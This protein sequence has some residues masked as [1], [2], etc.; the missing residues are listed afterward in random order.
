MATSLH[1]LQATEREEEGASG[2]GSGGG[3]S[4][5]SSRAIFYSY[6][7]PFVSGARWAVKSFIYTREKGA[8]A[9]IAVVDNEAASGGRFIP[10]TESSFRLVYLF[11]LKYSTRQSILLPQWRLAKILSFCGVFPQHKLSHVN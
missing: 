1:P 8:R 7:Y 5:L 11:S 6:R 9:I 2:C 10:E 3:W 4:D